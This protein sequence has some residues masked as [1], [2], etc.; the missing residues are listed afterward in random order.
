MQKLHF[1]MLLV[2]PLLEGSCGQ[3]IN[4]SSADPIH[5]QSTQ[6]IKVGKAPGC[7]EVA[8]LNH[9][10]LPDLIV[11]NEQDSS[12][13]ILLSKG[14]AQFEE[15][16]GSPFPAG[17]GVNDVAIGDFNGDGHLDLVFANHERRYV[18]LLL[19]NG[20]GQ[21][22]AAPRS[23]FPVEVIPHTHGIA[24]GDFN[25]DGR[26]DIVTDSWGN[27]QIEVLFGDSIQGFKVPGSF[28]KVGKHPYQRL[29]VAD[30]N[31][32]GNPDIVTTN[33]DGNN[34]TIL[35]GDGK[36]GFRE[37]PGSPVA[38]GDSPFGLAIGD[39]NQDGIPDLAIINSPASTADGTG[40]N[41]LTVLYGDG[42]GKFTPMK[43]SPV[44]SGKIPNRVAIGDING[45]GVDDIVVSD[46][47]VDTVYLFLMSKNSSVQS[48][49]AIRV[50]NHPKGVAIADINADGK[51]DILVCNNLDDDISIILGK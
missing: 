1:L 15:A 40:K 44:Q 22:V 19:G 45:D 26:L 20:R 51:G 43:G 11:T 17:H 9:D 18:T 42:T 49:T 30:I 23:P 39:L 27:N 3:S 38:C 35:L 32:D 6:R 37:A 13:T 21:F 24:A 16:Q 41:G 4:P 12:V 33:L 46:N 34:T 25:K 47:A 28:F 5:A 31:R 14:H 7:I 36:G 2:G 50:G 8:D 48:S 29:R 10:Q